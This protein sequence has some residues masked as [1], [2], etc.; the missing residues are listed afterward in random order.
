[1]LISLGVGPA[2]F[3]TKSNINQTFG[4]ANLNGKPY[5]ATG[6]SVSFSSSKW[7]WGGAAQIGLSYALKDPSW[8]L[9]FNYTCAISK[10]Y[11]N[12]YSASFTTHLVGGYTDFGTLFVNTKRQIRAQVFNFTINKEFS[13]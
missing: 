13:L 4:F 5:E 10:K 9:D 8:I 6:D 11:K 1:M 7:V 2:I 12:S 3:G